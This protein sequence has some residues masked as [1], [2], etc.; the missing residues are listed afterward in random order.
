MAS[1]RE[2]LAGALCIVAGLIHGGLGPEHFAQWWGYGVFFASAAALQIILGLGLVLDAIDPAHPRASTLRAGLVIV[3]ILVNVGLVLAYLVSR[4][5]GIPLGPEA[6]DVEAVG[7]LDLAT[8]LVE[9]A[10]VA[11]LVPSLKAAP[12]NLTR[13]TSPRTR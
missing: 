6:G 11:L 2:R 5:L 3:T 13:W 8:Q 9:V 10:L 1:P 7:I 12:R 4:T